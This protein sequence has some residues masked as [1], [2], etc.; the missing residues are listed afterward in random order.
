MK[1]ILLYRKAIINF[2]FVLFLNESNNSVATENIQLGIHQVGL[3]DDVG[4]DLPTLVLSSQDTPQLITTFIIG[5]L[6]SSFFPFPNTY[7]DFDCH[8]K[9]ILRMVD[10]SL[11]L[12]ESLTTWRILTVGEI[13]QQQVV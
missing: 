11:L 9:N 2:F 8:R 7:H 6:C 13:T 3:L 1:F 5:D 10:A 4:I 12:D